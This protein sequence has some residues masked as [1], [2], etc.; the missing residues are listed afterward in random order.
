MRSWENFY[1]MGEEYTLDMAAAQSD[2]GSYL[3]Y[4]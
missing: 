3:A 4:K 2:Y 1:N